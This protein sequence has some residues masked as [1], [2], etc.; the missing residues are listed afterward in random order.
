MPSTSSLG[1]T[2]KQTTH[3]PLQPNSPSP[4]PQ[5]PS[6]ILKQ[7]Y[8]PQKSAVRIRSLRHKRHAI[9]FHERRRRNSVQTE[10]V[11]RLAGLDRHHELLAVLRE[12]ASAVV[13]VEETVQPSAVRENVRAVFDDEAVGFGARGQEALVEQGVVPLFEGLEGGERVGV[14]LH[15]SVG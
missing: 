2:K 11:D 5:V 15:V 1:A 12:N 10:Q 14:V 8:R 3:H 7:R 6:R 13:I 4:N 9:S